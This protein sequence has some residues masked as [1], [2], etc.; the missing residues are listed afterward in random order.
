MSSTGRESPIT[1]NAVMSMACS[2]HIYGWVGPY[3]DSEVY[4]LYGT[5]V[6][7]LLDNWSECT[8]IGIK[9]QDMYDE[10]LTVVS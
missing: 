6:P 4:S 1:I 7:S 9:H 3:S 2:D 10:G 5:G 8:T